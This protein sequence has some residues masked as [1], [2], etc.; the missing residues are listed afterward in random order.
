[1]WRWGCSTDCSVAIISPSRLRNCAGLYAPTKENNLGQAANAWI[2]VSVG[3]VC[4][5]PYEAVPLYTLL[6]GGWF[7]LLQV[8]YKSGRMRT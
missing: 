4:P 7:G 1:M 3:I 8:H 2:R 5:G 6:C